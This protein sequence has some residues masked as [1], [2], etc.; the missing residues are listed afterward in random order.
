G[1]QTAVA[2]RNAQLYQEIV[3]LSGELEKM[4]EARTQDLENA[5]AELTRQRDRAET[6]YRITS[7][8][9]ATLDLERVLER[10][11]HLFVDALGV[12]HGTIML[13]DQETGYLTLKAT[14]EP[15]R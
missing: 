1:T 5:L 3:H 11:L 10:A 15:D 14:L 9:G 2:M 12:E 8:L 13:I 7:E 4:V 6:L